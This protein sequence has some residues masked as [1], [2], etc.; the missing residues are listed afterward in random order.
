MHYILLQTCCDQ[1]DDRLDA[2]DLTSKVIVVD[3][4]SDKM[5]QH[6]LSHY[7]LF[8][9]LP[10]LQ[11]STTAPDKQKEAPKAPIMP[12]KPLENG[13]F[14][15]Y[16]AENGYFLC[17]NFT[18]PIDPFSRFPCGSPNLQ[19]PLAPLSRVSCFSNPL[20]SRKARVFLSGCGR[21]SP[22]GR[23]AAPSPRKGHRPLTH[24]SRFP[25]GCL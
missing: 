24:F 18:L 20:D 8:P 5:C 17:I 25:V 2:T 21:G 22:T 10:R 14:L 9:I 15:R 23:G 6:N 12:L 1:I 19:L 13:C 4:S 16:T 11:I 7:T 3:S